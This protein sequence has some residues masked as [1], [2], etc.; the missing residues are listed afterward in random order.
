[1]IRIC[2]I[3]LC[4]ALF[5]GQAWAGNPG[6]LIKPYDS[7]DSYSKIPDIDTTLP[8][9][10]EL[11]PCDECAE[12]RS[13]LERCREFIADPYGI[14]I[15]IETLDDTR[16]QQ[17]EKQL[18]REKWVERLNSDIEEMLQKLNTY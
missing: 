7:E 11:K 2:T 6:N 12:I 17:L 4:C 9:D 10:T 18:E 8:Y 5:M 14:K 1:M 3:L 16:V 13:I 15:T